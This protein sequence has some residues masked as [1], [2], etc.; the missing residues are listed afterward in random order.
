[1]EDWMKDTLGV[2]KTQ[3]KLLL[4]ERSD[5][6]SEHI[7]DDALR[8]TRANILN[9]FHGLATNSEI[10]KGDSI[11]IF[12]SGHGSSYQCLDCRRAIF[13]DTDSSWK[14]SSAPDSA[15]EVEFHKDR[16]PIEAICPIDRD[17][18]ENGAHIPDI[19]DREI[20]N[21]LAKI[22]QMTGAYI[23]VILDCCHSGGATKAPQEGSVR[24]TRPLGQKTFVRMLDCAKDSMGGWS[25][26]RDVWEKKWLPD[27]GSHI[28]LAACRDYQLAK[29]TEQD[30]HGYRGVFT[31][32]LVKTLTSGVL[33]EGSTY[34]DLIDALP[35]W[36]SQTP[37]VAGNRKKERLW[38]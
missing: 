33:N 26:Y 20:N 23:T 22:H 5:T 36:D 6:S 19:S 35:K 28:V 29:E 15:L 2:P 10:K 27:M 4:G 25:G 16:C 31:S 12:F 1:M 3:I 24:A 8:P 7:P 34:V 14:T 38:C 11:I 17:S 32:A 18:L 13:G 30:G 37:V 9:T 21:I